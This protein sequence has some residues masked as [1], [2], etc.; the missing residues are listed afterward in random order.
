MLAMAGMLLRLTPTSELVE[1][2]ESVG[3]P[4]EPVNHIRSRTALIHWN[5]SV[6][7][8]KSR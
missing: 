3:L 4:E 7:R 8:R 6:S 5:S 1:V 2:E